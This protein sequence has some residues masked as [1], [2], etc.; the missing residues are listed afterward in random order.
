[1][2]PDCE[3]KCRNGDA[4]RSSEPSRWLTAGCISDDD[5][6][7]EIREIDVVNLRD[8]TVGVTIVAERGDEVVSEDGFRFGPK[9]GRAT[10]GVYLKES[11]MS[12]EGDLELTISAD[13]I[14]EASL[15]TE[16][17]AQESEDDECVSAFSP[18]DEN[19]GGMYYAEA[20]C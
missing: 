17:V 13:S 15:F 3:P 7:V 14:D 5:P 8:E 12:G 20:E 10:G 16:S 4:A 18:V 2:F 6:Q 19:G 11:W 9:Q 1:M